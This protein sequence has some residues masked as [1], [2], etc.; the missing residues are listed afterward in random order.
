MYN[1]CHE[2]K[3]TNSE[4]CPNDLHNLTRKCEFGTAGELGFL[5]KK[6]TGCVG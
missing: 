3:H 2:E 5:V 1:A 4:Q 6:Y